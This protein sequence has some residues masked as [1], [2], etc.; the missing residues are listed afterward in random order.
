MIRQRNNN[1][2]LLL[3]LLLLLRT[4]FQPT[5]DKTWDCKLASD[6][7]QFRYFTEESKYNRLIFYFVGHE[8]QMRSVFYNFGRSA[9]L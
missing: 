4:H 8:G 5:I 3:L 1:K 9:I 2:I 7:L 6:N